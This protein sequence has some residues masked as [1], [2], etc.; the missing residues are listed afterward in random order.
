[1][2]GLEEE[3]CEEDEAWN[4]PRQ[5]DVGG[6]VSAS[7]FETRRK[8]QPDW[9][10][11]QQQ[12]AFWLEAVPKYEGDTTLVARWLRSDRNMA[13]AVGE[14]G[15]VYDTANDAIYFPTLEQAEDFLAVIETD[16]YGKRRSTGLAAEP[17][18]VY[19]IDKPNDWDGPSAWDMNTRSWV[20]AQGVVRAAT[21]TKKNP[22]LRHNPRQSDVGW[23]QS[24]LAHLRALQWVYTT[25]HWTSAGPNSYSD[26]LLLQ[27]LYEGLDKPID[28]LGERMVAYFGPQSVDPRDINKLVNQLLVNCEERGLSGLDC[29]YELEDWLQAGLRMAWKANQDSGD[30]FSLGIDDYLMGLA[31]DRDEAIYLLKQRLGSP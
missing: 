12:A 27:R 9:R 3:W 13:A 15:A 31:N 29:L 21:Q 20:P 16:A 1:M 7:A 23:Y 25:S 10:K 24:I 4:N 17:I 22:R 18:G 28:A 5:S 6:F 19:W 26:H 30:E 14:W 2:L 8:W 11:I